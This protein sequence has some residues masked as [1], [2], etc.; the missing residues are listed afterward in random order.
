[1]NE[2]ENEFVLI[3]DFDVLPGE[4]DGQVCDFVTTPSLGGSLVQPLGLSVARRSEERGARAPD[5]HEPSRGSWDPLPRAPVG[6]CCG[7]RGCDVIA[8]TRPKCLQPL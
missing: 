1:M 3:L 5:I 6:L 8:V 2:Q 4:M 7:G